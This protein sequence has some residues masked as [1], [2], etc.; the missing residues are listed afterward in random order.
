MSSKYSLPNLSALAD[1]YDSDNERKND[2]DGNCG[3]LS[4]P[5][6]KIS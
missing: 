5:K 2:F 4:L 1:T 3:N 6:R